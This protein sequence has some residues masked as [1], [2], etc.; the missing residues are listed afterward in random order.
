MQIPDAGHAVDSLVKRCLIWEAS[1]QV[2]I[3]E[4][5]GANE[6]IRSLQVVAWY[7]RD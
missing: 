2:V 1:I 5:F 4:L 6:A 3:V 7:Q